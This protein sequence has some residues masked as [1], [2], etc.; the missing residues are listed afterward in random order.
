MKTIYYSRAAFTMVEMAVVIGVIALITAMSVSMGVDV[1]ETYRR[2]ATQNRMDE[3]EK[4]LLKFRELN[5]RLPCPGN[6]TLA[7]TSTNYGLEASNPGSCIDDDADNED[8]DFDAGYFTTTAPTGVPSGSVPVKTLGLPVDY[9]YDAWGRKFQYEVVV[10]MT[11]PGSFSISDP[12]SVCVDNG[13]RVYQETYPTN[14]DTITA[15]AVYALNSFGKNGIGGYG[16]DGTRLSTGTIGT[17]EAYNRHGT[18]LTTAPHYVY[19]SSVKGQQ[20]TT[21]YYDDILRFKNF[22]QLLTDADRKRDY[23]RGP[24]ALMM[25]EGTNSTSYAFARFT[26]GRLSSS[27]TSG[28]VITDVSGTKIDD[29]VFAAFLPDNTHLLVYGDPVSGSNYCNVFPVYDTALGIAEQQNFSCHL[30]DSDFGFSAGAGTFVFSTTTSPYVQMWK[31]HNNQYSQVMNPVLPALSASPVHVT[32]SDDG[33]YLTFSYASSDIT[34]IYALRN[35]KYRKITDP[36]GSGSGYTNAISP[37]GRYYMVASQ[38]GSDTEAELWRNDAGVFSYV[39]LTTISGMPDPNVI[40]FSPDSKMV[41]FS[42][43]TAPDTQLAVFNI[44]PTDDSL[45]AVTLSAQPAIGNPFVVSFTK[46]NSHILVTTGDSTLS[47]PFRL[48]RRST[49]SS[50]TLQSWPSITTGVAGAGSNIGIFSR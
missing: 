42:G 7:T 21:G 11:Y 15:G 13:I 26:C 46:D 27:T 16:R 35:G 10:D 19:V 33:H 18:G 39:G 49:P 17:L 2:T 34:H 41:A 4:A 6:P 25:H 12:A 31:W 37:D 44:D 24:H 38:S 40:Q 30:N 3:I 50:Y 8:A 28:F 45:D 14:T 29:K 5:D 23:Y 47:A 48:Y 9:M 22:S 36:V 32:L 1:L 43:G 20:N